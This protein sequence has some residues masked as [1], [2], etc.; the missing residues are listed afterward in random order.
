MILK[1]LKRVS[2]VTLAIVV[3]LIVIGFFY[4]KLPQFGT[5]PEGERLTSLER[6]FNY[7]DG[8]FE[9]IHITPDLTEGYSLAEV[10]WEFFTNR[11]ERRRPIDIIPS[12]KTDLLH[13]PIDQDVL[14]WFG[15][16]SYFMQIDGKRILVDPVFS[17]NASPIPGTVTSFN[18]TDR[19]TVYDL[20]EIDY[21]FISH[22][23]YDHVDYETLT[24]LQT[25][26]KKVICGL[27]V[28]AHFEQ[29]GYTPES[30]IERNWNESV[31]L[32]SGFVAHVTPARHFSGR[33]L[34]RNNT[35]W[36]SF[37]L[38]TPS[39]KIYMGGDSGYDTHFSD[40]GN[41]FG[42]IDLAILDNGQYDKKWK[43]IHT[44]P[45]EVLQAAH[46]VKAKRLFPVHSSK[47]V[48][49][50]H[51]WDEPLMRVTELN[52]ISADPMPLVTPI[53]GELV[54]LHDET[55]IFKP[56]WVGVR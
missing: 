16:S 15:H 56:W 8:K 19:F 32:D 25:K 27:G 24:K 5:S 37:V 41:A 39:L 1:V 30:I 17:G 2:L 3:L 21:L 6:S 36:V 35:L 11:N 44:M 50:N 47:F 54:F 12:V 51:P 7:K 48:L 10:T 46:D 23:H 4:M 28:G 49:A 13:L 53:I 34:S 52:S 29:W 31:S 38:Q 22:D 14:V 18:G 45:E 43:Y 33:G 40:I 55:H 26:T 20:P 9:N 42:P